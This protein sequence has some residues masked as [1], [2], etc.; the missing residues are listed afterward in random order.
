MLISNQDWEKHAVKLFEESVILF[1][2]MVSICILVFFWKYLSFT[3]A[4]SPAIAVSFFLSSFIF[5]EIQYKLQEFAP[6]PNSTL[7]S[8]SLRASTV[9]NGLRECYFYF[10]VFWDHLMY[11]SDFWK[12]IS[13]VQVLG[14]V[15]SVAILLFGHEQLIYRV[16]RAFLNLI[17]FD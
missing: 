3:F 5:A 1:S 12:Y 13:A 16:H 6:K 14:G 11:L 17:S 2:S 9:F 10:Q 4:S 15:E 7:K 8:R